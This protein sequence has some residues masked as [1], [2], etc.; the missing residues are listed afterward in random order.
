[1]ASPS[2]SSTSSSADPCV[3]K[4]FDLVNWDNLSAIACT[5]VQ[6]PKGTGCHWEEQFWGGYNLVCFLHLHDPQKIVIIARV[7]LLSEGAMSDDHDS[8]ISKRI[9]S[10][11][12]TMKYVET[13]ITI[14]VP[15]V[16][17]HNARAEEDV[18]S[19]Y[20]LMSKVD[21][22]PL[23]S[24]WDDM[25]DE[26]RRIVIQQVI[27]ILLELWSHRFDKKGALFD[28]SNGSLCI[29]SSSLFVDPED[30][31]TRHCLLTTS[32]SHAADY[33]L[34]YANA[35]LRDIDESNFGSDTKPYIHSQAWF[36]RSLIPAL[37]NPSI[38][39]HGCPL[40]PG[41]FHSQNIMIT[42]IISSH[43]RITAVID[44]EFSGPDFASSFAQYPLFIVDHP[45]WDSDHPL[46]KRNVRDRV[47]FDELIL[48]AERNRNPVDDFYGI[49]LFHQA[50]YFPGMYSLV[51]PLLFAY[52]FG[53]DEDFSTDYYWALMENGILNRDQKRFEQER[54]VWLEACQVLGEEVV[55]VNMTRTEFRDLVSKSQEKFNNEGSVCR[56]F[57]SSR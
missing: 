16:F 43:P 2:V 14:P 25:D 36:M 51:Y 39:I 47:M 54:E 35:Q 19:P 9:E 20:I 5:L 55:D 28:G 32:Y 21:G 34:A 15:H 45:H 11:V 50:M 1:M 44:W 27:D 23:S 7:P 40:S 22:V 12:V 26:R 52:V 38:D 46:R 24:V 49:Y 17:H 56:W 53:D 41:D 8:A 18:H 31:G 4:T 57:V 3:Q 13:R 10:E 37:F 29:Q 30:T 6:L 48:E 33:W 42:D